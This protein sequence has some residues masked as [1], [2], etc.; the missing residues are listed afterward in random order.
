MKA[1]S[2]STVKNL[3]L[4]VATAMLLSSCGGGGGSAG[5]AEQTPV[6]TAEVAAGVE[7]LQVGVLAAPSTT[8]VAGADGG[9]VLTADSASLQ[10]LAP[11]EVL[12]LPASPA[13]GLP[14]PYVGNVVS[15]VTA[16]GATVITLTSANVEDAYTALQWDIDTAQTGATVVGVI[17]PEKATARFSVQPA[18]ANQAG[19]TLTGNLQFVDSSLNGSIKLEHE[20]EYQGKKVVLFA[21]VDLAKVSVRSKGIFDVKNPAAA[22]GWAE[23]TAVVKGDVGAKVG[24]SAPDLV[25]IPTLADLLSSQKIWDQLKW[26]GSDQFKLEGLE[27]DDKKGRFPL[28][29]VVLTPC[30]AGVCPVTFKGNLPNAAI[31]SFSLAPTVVLWIYLDMNGKV[32]ISGETGVRMSG[33]HFEQ[34]YEFKAIR[35]SLEATRIDVVTPQ[36]IEVYGNGKFDAAQR[37]G[38]SVAADIL[39]GGIRPAAVNAFVGAKFEGKL[40]G[41]L[42]YAIKPADGWRG[43]GCWSGKVSA[44]T[45]LDANFRLKAQVPVNL[46]F[47]KFQLGNVVELALSGQ[48]IDFYEKD[49][50]NTCQARNDTGIRLC[51]AAGSDT[52]VSCASAAAIALNPAQDGMTGRD[53]DPA[54]NSNA[55]GKL[56]FSYTKLGSNGQPLA[57]QNETYSESGSE[58]AGTHW[59]CV[60]DNVTGLIWENKTAGGTRAGD[61][62]YTNFSAA[63][64]ADVSAYVATVNGLGL[65]GFGDWRLPTVEELHGLVDYGVAFPGPTIDAG[66]FPNTRVGNFWSSSPVA[67]D[68]SRAWHVNFNNG[69]VHWNLLRVFPSAAVRLVRASQ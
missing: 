29:G 18:A 52:L 2:K 58:A 62:T 13:Q 51:Y 69:F 60:R 55:D 37:L 48:P 32:S 6:V 49:L 1:Q 30:P 20:L 3:L 10:D 17:A 54:T 59:S 67:G 14:F 19:L 15:T 21:E 22:N 64:S 34:G 24:L 23:F 8:I 41:D 40:E 45:Q 53:A 47:S 9:L 36:T 35:A 66:Y 61:N 16:G 33:H 68:S 57:I 7:S 44:G 56:G 12:F 25:E 43:K 50:G 11:G 46:G 65:C 26:K 42:A 31:R 38:I 63:L 4:V 27:G 39:V 28:G 5:T